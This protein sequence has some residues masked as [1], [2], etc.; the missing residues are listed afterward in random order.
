MQALLDF[1]EAFVL[2]CDRLDPG[3]LRLGE[4]RLLDGLLKH[5]LEDLL[6]LEVHQVA[7]CLQLGVVMKQKLK[8]VYRHISY[9]GN[10]DEVVARL[11]VLLQH[12]EEAE[13]RTRDVRV[14]VDDLAEF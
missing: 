4:E 10:G 13:E 3:L 14:A 9:H 12:V 2:G 7:L 1:P 11:C 6:V 8:R 5:R